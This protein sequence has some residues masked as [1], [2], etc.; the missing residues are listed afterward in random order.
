MAEARHRGVAGAD[1]RNAGPLTA[2]RPETITPEE[3]QA[4]FEATAA[5]IAQPVTRE[6]LLARAAKI[7]AEGFA[8]PPPL[9]RG[10][11]EFGWD[12]LKYAAHPDWVI[13]IRDADRTLP[14]TCLCLL[15]GRPALIHPR[16]GLIFAVAIGS[17]GVAARLPGE[18]F[19]ALR[20]Y[21]LGRLG[22]D[23]S[24]VASG[25]DWARRAFESA[26]V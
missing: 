2:L 12:Q 25:T 14:E 3:L 23:W 6:R 9:I 4:R 20:A 22:A 15:Y 26:A 21:D 7:R 13:F 10:P 19:S 16:T 8:P 24:A 11:G 5:R 17:I 1:P 18:P